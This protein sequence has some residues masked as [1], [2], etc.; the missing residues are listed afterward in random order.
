MYKKPTISFFESR[1]L[2]CSKVQREPEHLNGVY[3]ELV[4]A[5]IVCLEDS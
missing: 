5:L 1:C 3:K 2:Q 4:L